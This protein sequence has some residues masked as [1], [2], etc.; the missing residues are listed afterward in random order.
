M[1]KLAMYI[2]SSFVFIG[3]LCA[4]TKVTVDVNLDVKRKIADITLTDRN[5]FITIH[6]DVDEREWDGDNFISD[7][8]DE[9]LNGL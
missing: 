7:L 4:Q 5:K 1:Q 8:K 2:V 9:F 6:A 3:S